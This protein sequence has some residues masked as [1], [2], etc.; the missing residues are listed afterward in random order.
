LAIQAGDAQKALDLLTKGQS[1]DLVSP[2][3]YLRGLA[4]LQLH[5]AGNATAAFKI[6]TRYKGASYSN[7]TSMPFPMNNY[8]L[9]LLGLG[10]AYAM[11][12]DKTDAK[13]AYD[14]FFTEWKN[15][16]PG[17]AVMAQAKKEY[18]AL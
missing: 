17:L 2:G 10:R 8:A 5:D 7:Q 14:R 12:A 3:S 1:F 13:A 16:D 15:A 4:Y 9:G 18:A 11:A 6:A